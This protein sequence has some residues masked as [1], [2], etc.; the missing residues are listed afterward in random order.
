MKE[1]L[2]KKNQSVEKVFQII[3]IMAETKGPMRLQDISVRLGLPTSTV[4]QFLNTLMTYNYVNQNLGYD[5]LN[6]RFCFMP[7]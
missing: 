7:A 2:A 3:E 5:I 4:L 6:S 1:K